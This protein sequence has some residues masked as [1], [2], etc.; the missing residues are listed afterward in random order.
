MNKLIQMMLI[1]KIKILMSQNNIGKELFNRISNALQSLIKPP[2]IQMMI[3][4]GV[5]VQPSKVSAILC[6]ILKNYHQIFLHVTRKNSLIKKLI[7]MKHKM[8]NKKL[9]LLNIILVK[10]LLDI[11]INHKKLK[12]LKHLHQI[13]LKL[14]KI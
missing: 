8:Y 10:N 1:L 5:K 11:K 9:I 3:A 4:L 13:I 2:V 14:P 6:R 7:M 12:K